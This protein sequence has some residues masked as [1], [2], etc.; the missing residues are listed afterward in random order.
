M[1][2]DSEE[3]S[4]KGKSKTLPSVTVLDRRVVLTGRWIKTAS[5]K[6]EELYEGKGVEN[7][8]QFINEVKKSGIKADILTFAQ[9][10]EE[11]GPRYGYHWEWD[12]AAVIPTTSYLEWWNNRL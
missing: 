11:G 6:D 2:S 7:P 10:L 8:E 1:Y 3:I 5:V 9:S 12:N 4:I